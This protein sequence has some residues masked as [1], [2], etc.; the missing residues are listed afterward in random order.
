MQKS[1]LVAVITG[2][3][4]LEVQSGEYLGKDDIVGFEDDYGRFQ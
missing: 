1:A 3:D 4:M 2:A